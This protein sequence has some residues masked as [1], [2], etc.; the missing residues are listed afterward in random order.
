MNQPA[1]N[2]SHEIQNGTPHSPSLDLLERELPHVGDNMIP[3]GELVGRVT[4][5]VYAELTELAE[6]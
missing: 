2:G 5:A 1:T 4:Q 6:T 3:L